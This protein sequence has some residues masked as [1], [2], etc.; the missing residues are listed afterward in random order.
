MPYVPP[1]LRPGY[2]APAYVPPPRPGP[3]TVRFPTNVN[4]TATT[5]V[6]PPAPV[7]SFFTPRPHNATARKT[8]LKPVDSIKLNL[9]PPAYPASRVRSLPP[10]FQKAI[11]NKYGMS[12]L[13]EEWDGRSRTRRKSRARRHKPSKK[14]RR[15]RKQTR[16]H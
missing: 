5:N 8:A 10:K 15:Q 4:D 12:A 1:H 7:G 16:R 13:K 14:S 6:V 9:A 3:G 2:I 11:T